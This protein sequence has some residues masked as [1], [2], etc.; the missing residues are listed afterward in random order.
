MLPSFERSKRR[1]RS[2]RESK[3][4]SAGCLCHRS[5]SLAF[6]L[7]YVIFAVAF[8]TAN[9]SNTIKVDVPGNMETGLLE[10]NSA[11]GEALRDHSVARNLNIYTT[12]GNTKVRVGLYQHRILT[13]KGTSGGAFNPARVFGPGKLSCFPSTKTDAQFDAA[14]VG[15]FW[16]NHWFYWFGDLTA[17]AIQSD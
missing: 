2:F 14:L 1:Q 5:H 9:T 12:S 15:G 4:G 11:A 6:I 8:D 13:W 10:E 3:V 17:A 7:V 16:D